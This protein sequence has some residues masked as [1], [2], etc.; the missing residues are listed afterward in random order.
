MKRLKQ[1][2]ELLFVFTKL[3]DY[4]ANFFVKT[5]T[6]FFFIEMDR[7]SHVTVPLK[8]QV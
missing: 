7:K 3:F 5:K 2:R 8:P 1:F 6:I 4:K